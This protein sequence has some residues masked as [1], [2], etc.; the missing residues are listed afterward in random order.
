MQNTVWLYYNDQ[1]QKFVSF[2]VEDLLLYQI[3]TY[4][5]SVGVDSLNAET[6]TDE[7]T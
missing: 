4:I 5:I 2:Q 3:L 6:W 7:E 1:M